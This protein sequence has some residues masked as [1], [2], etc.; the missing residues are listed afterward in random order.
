MLPTDCAD[1]VKLEEQYPGANY[2]PDIMAYYEVVSDFVPTHKRNVL[3][4]K[5]A[6]PGAGACPPVSGGGG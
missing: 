4:R 2:D 5:A 6:D 3:F 1:T